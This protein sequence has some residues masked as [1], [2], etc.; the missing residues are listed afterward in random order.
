MAKRKFRKG[1]KV[2]Y[3]RNNTATIRKGSAGE[4]VSDENVNGIVVLHFRRRRKGDTNR[5][6][7]KNLALVT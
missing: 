3:T 5:I 6:S 1:D 4:C 7:A 2:K